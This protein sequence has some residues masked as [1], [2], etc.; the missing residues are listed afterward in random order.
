MRVFG[1]VFAALL[2]L[3][4]RA[5]AA[6]PAHH[7]APAPR[8]VASD[9]IVLPATVTPLRYA[10]EF[11]PDI[12]KRTFTGQVAT[13]IEVL[14]ATKTLML[15]AADL[16]FSQ[17][18][19]SGRAEAP[20][21]SYDKT[22]ETATL[23]FAKTVAPGRY[24]LTIAYSGLINQHA[25][26]L[27]AVDYDGVGGR[28]RALFTQ[29]ENSD[30]RRFLPC[31][32][33]PNRKA[34][35]TLTA[36]VPADQLAVS[37]MPVA[38]REAAGPGLSR[39]TFAPSPKMSSYLLYFSV[40]DFERIARRVG[41]VEVGVV[42]KRGDAKKAAYALDAAEHL[43]PYYEHYFGV[44][45]PLP[46]LDLIAAPGS[47]QFFGA[48]ENWGAILYFE[49]DILIDPR[50]ST[51]GDKQNVYTTVAHEM[52]HQWFGD[53]V[54]MDWWQDL[55]LNE[56]FASWMQSK[57][58]DH[59]HPEWKLGLQDMSSKQFAM[60]VDAL[61]GTHPI[62]QPVRDVLQA[63][64]AFDGAITYAKGAAVIKMLEAYVGEDAWR[65][66][67]RNY[68]R[69]HAYGNT[70]TDQL[71]DEIDAVSPRKIRDIAH[72]FTLQAGVPLVRVT[73]DGAGLKLTQDRFGLDDASK[74]PRTWRVPVVAAG[75]GKTWRG[76]VSADQPALVPLDPASGPVVNAGQTGYFRTLYA[77]AL[78]A[79][80]SARFG[81]LDAADQLGVFDDTSALGMAG[82]EPIS[83]LLDLVGHVPADADPTLLSAEV[84]E[85]RQVDRLYDGL[86]SQARYRAWARG[87]LA[88]VMNTLG[89]DPKP[90]EA[91][92]AAIL[93]GTVIAALGQFD[94]PAVVAEARKRFAGY[95]VDPA[96]LPASTRRAILTVAAQQADAR[97][98]DQFH[99]LARAAKSPL[100]KD[101]LYRLLASARDPAL[102]Q[103]ALDLVFSTEIDSTTGPN[104]IDAVSNQHP[105]M[106]FDFSVS[107]L[108]AL[109]AELE[110]DSRTQYLPGLVSG[111]H[112]LGLIGKLD[113]FAAAHIPPG[114]RADVVKAQS[115]VRLA[116]AQ[117]EARVPEIDRWLAAHGG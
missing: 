25:A 2:A 13:D 116:A 65:T 84:G 14:S 15:N 17:V 29:F 37:N 85:L 41:K 8:A 66:G 117:R 90:G 9:R 36:V 43:L 45:F 111:A 96:S 86:P 60:G 34:V 112:D 40:G 28:Q 19:L 70:V 83:D 10:L 81:S 61:T 98:W 27:F 78:F 24:R 79:R 82:Y 32:D 80:I 114:A 53:L 12:S 42:F 26:G 92:N 75:G 88:P 21:V 47:S 101:E 5:A 69:K 48:M 35:F 51:D 87:A 63:N 52:A 20:A 44:N 110:P 4:V 7:H 39:I 77:P 31:W 93:R 50:I 99:A 6:K 16:S 91:A 38:K 49:R 105:E 107:H 71:W 102:A 62:I 58:T 55:W 100:E 94:D 115:N 72:G 97:T 106:A 67:V 89:W 1:I 56:G 11:K 22:Q 73:P 104:I 54:T 46:K 18:A 95:V 64:Q 109:Y 108:D 103:H 30:A 74:T 57:A 33:E 23:T 3:G 76:V 68:M 113:A 59:F